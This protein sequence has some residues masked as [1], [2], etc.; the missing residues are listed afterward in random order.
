M[1]ILLLA[2]GLGFPIISFAAGK[3]CS[4]VFSMNETAEK[5]RAPASADDARKYI[6]AELANEADPQI[7]RFITRQILNASFSAQADRD[8]QIQSVATLLKRRVDLKKL[9]DCV[10]D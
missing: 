10:V 7:L 5:D 6:N 9:T 8:K 1:K 3:P 2:L 4:N